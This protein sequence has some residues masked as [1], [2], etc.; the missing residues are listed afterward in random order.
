MTSGQPVLVLTPEGRAAGR[1]ATGT[2]V[3][4]LLVW[5]ETWIRKRTTAKAEIELRSAALEADALPL[6]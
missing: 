1:V 3:F 2:P 4:K 5:L 6:G